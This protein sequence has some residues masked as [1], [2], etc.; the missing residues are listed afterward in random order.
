MGW[1]RHNIWKPVFFINF[2]WCK[3]FSFILLLIFINCQIRYVYLTQ[4]SKNLLFWKK[5]S[6]HMVWHW[7]WYVLGPDTNTMK[8]PSQSCAVF[9]WIWKGG[10]WKDSR[11]IFPKIS[12]NLLRWFG[13]ILTH[14][15]KMTGLHLVA[16][17]GRR[18]NTKSTRSKRRLRS[19]FF[20]HFFPSL[21]KKYIQSIRRFRGGLTCDKASLCQS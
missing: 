12:P 18:E 3:Y 8:T 13:P 16:L 6:L 19:L 14:F 15:F 4:T 1:L 17:C 5:L 7:A 10:I 11:N 20:S 21:L 9:V 2:K